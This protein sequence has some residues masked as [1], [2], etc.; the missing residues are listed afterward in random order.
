[1]KEPEGTIMKVLIEL[2]EQGAQ[3]IGLLAM[4][5]IGGFVHYIG[6]VTKKRKKF[7]IMEL[8]GETVVACFAGFLVALLCESQGW[9]GPLMIAAVA[10]A[11]HMG[12]RI[13]D[14]L[15][16]GLLT[17]LRTKYPSLFKDMPNE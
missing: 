8:I 13:I 10:I 11:G 4:G 6:Q 12:N 2:V 15:E 17:L 14:L 3:Y 5:A 9:N 7:R 1:M 16:Q